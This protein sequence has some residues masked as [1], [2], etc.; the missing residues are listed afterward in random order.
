MFGK[1]INTNKN[2]QKDEEERYSPFGKDAIKSST[3][4]TMAKDKLSL[5][6]N[7]IQIFSDKEEDFRKSFS[8]KKVVDQ[9]DSPFFEEHKNNEEK[10]FQIKT[11]FFEQDQK[12]SQVNQKNFL[13]KGNKEESEKTKEEDLIVFDKKSTIEESK[14][15]L[16]SQESFLSKKNLLEK[17][18]EGNTSFDKDS[19]EDSYQLALEKEV[20]KPSLEKKEGVFLKKDHFIANGYSKK[21]VKSKDEVGG[22]VKIHSSFFSFRKMI[23]F[24]VGIL[25]VF[26]LAGSGYYLEQQHHWI[27]WLEKKEEDGP[28]I[29][30]P[31]EPI[32][33]PEKE[34]PLVTKSIYASDRVNVILLQEEESLS[35]KIEEIRQELSKYPEENKIFIFSFGMGDNVLL[36]GEVFPSFTSSVEKSFSVSSWFL[37]ATFDGKTT[38]FGLVGKLSS[39]TKAKEVFQMNESKTKEFFSLLYPEDLNF[40]NNLVSFSDSVYQ[41]KTIRYWNMDAT[42]T[43]SF[44]YSLFDKNFLIGTSKNSMRIFLDNI[45]EIENFMEEASLINESVL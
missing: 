2:I 29:L 19:F 40:S 12:N 35:L 21:Y 24:F 20:Q 10:L 45:V 33:P 32:T 25:V 36:F 7:T 43:Y 41:E 4:R 37:L 13:S 6:K 11:D 26:L 1:K 28:P 23:G 14:T 5:E 16:S 22:S 30:I 17:V 31:I 18:D 8:E 42:N 3:I 15:N 34:E 39:E 44:D 38:K 27:S 9:K